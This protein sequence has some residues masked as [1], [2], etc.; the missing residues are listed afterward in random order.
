[1]KRIA[2]LTGAK[3]RLRGRGSKFIERLTGQESPDPLHL[4]VSCLS[5]EKFEKASDGVTDL[6]EVVAA[7]Y[8]QWCRE[9]GLERPSLIIK[10]YA[11][12]ELV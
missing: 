2:G 11:Y 1:M 3:L 12:K 6:L 5:K 10:K 4:C 9:Q 7:E 8:A